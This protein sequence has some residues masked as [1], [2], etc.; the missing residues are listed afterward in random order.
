MDKTQT[1]IGRGEAVI[2]SATFPSRLS[3]DSMAMT[4]SVTLLS[5]M[6]SEDRSGSWSRFVLT[7]RPFIHGWLRRQGIHP[8]DAIDIEQDVMSVLLSELPRFQHNGSQGAFRCWLR[9]ITHN[10]LR[11]HRRRG[12]RESRLADLDVLADRLANDDD[13]L[14]KQWDRQHDRFLLESLWQT[15]RPDF[16]RK[17]LRSFEMQV[18]EE[19][20]PAET[21]AHLGMTKAAVI[22][23]KARVLCRLREEARRLNVG[24]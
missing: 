5:S 18:F 10:Q 3:S 6:Q 24:V 20:S 2:I 17:T 15:I 19:R 13:P 14:S 8:C 22:A 9:R 4:T 7:Y 21:A 16:T 12:N 11:R 1:L 23:A